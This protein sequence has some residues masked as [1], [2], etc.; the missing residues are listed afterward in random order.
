MLG[1]DYVDN[2]GLEKKKKHRKII[3]L[4]VTLIVLSRLHVTD[5]KD[6]DHSLL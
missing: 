1:K 4:S 2:H 5:D 6:N 3:I